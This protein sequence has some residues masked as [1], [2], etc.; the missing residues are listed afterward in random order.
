M[1]KSLLSLI[2]SVPAI[3]PGSQPGFVIFYVTNRCNFRC[4]FCFYGEEIKKGQKKDELSL[5]EI[6]KIAKTTGPLLQL[7]LTGG[8]PFLRNGLADIVHIFVR[9]TRPWFVTIPTNASMPD[10]MVEFLENVLPAHPNID[11]RIVF[12]IEGIGEEHDDIRSTPGSFEKIIES[13]RVLTSIRERFPNL[14]LDANSVFTARSE[15]TL[16]DTLRHLDENLAFDNLSITFARGDISDESLK[17]TS[18]EKYE[19]INRFLESLNR[20]KESRFLYPVWRGVR[21]VSRRNLIRTE[22]DDEFVAPCVAGRK[23]VVIGETGE[24]FPCEILGRSMG[25]LREFDFDL[26]LLMASAENDELRKWIVD[27]KCKCTFECA[28]TANV[29]WNITSYPKLAVAS[30]K[31]IGKKSS[32]D[33]SR[34]RSSPA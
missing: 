12:S 1:T 14:V 15:D 24:V 13:H 21:D 25:N 11:F 34:P 23:I 33:G 16:K 5:G 27:S 10:R 20:G 26:K 22:F 28:L 7:S 3:A 6:E 17:Q 4:N 32:E 18:R 19:D 30:L 31:N 9:H 2:R 8:E 29:A